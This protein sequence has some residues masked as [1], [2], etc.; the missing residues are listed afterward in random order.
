MVDGCEHLSVASVV[1]AARPPPSVA[2]SAH[3]IGANCSV[4]SSGRLGAITELAFLN[5]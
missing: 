5:G 1:I 3:R 2:I 4:M